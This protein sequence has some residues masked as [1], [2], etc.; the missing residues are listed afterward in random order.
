M[1]GEHRVTRSATSTTSPR[2]TWRPVADRTV[3]P[4]RDRAWTRRH[5]RGRPAT[6]ASRNTRRVTCSALWVQDD[7]AM[8]PRLTLNLGRAVR[9]VDR[10]VRQLGRVP[11]VHRRA[12]RPDD[13][14]NFGPASGFAYSPDRPDGRPR[15][16]RRLLRRGDGPAGG[17]HAAQRPADHAADPERRAT[18]LRVQP[19][20]RSG[21]ELR[22]GGAALLCTVRTAS[23]TCLRA[24]VGNFVAPDLKSPF[25]HQ[26]SLGVPAP[27]WRAPCRSRRTG[28]TRGTGTSSLP[29]QHQ[30]RVQPGDGRQL[31]VQRC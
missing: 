19:V 21:A 3:L 30:H 7:W 13:T 18:G 17:L 6:R 31:P 25:S 20:Q 22:S 1:P 28:S 14:N 8:S 5:S 4:A 24:N 16:V 12:D 10:R 29:R 26:A 9:P 11:A 27:A 15:R 23:P 2:G